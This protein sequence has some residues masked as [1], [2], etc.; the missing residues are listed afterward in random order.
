MFTDEAREISGPLE[1]GGAKKLSAEQSELLEEL[2]THESRWRRLRPKATK[3]KVSS[4]VARR[5]SAEILD[6]VGPLCIIRRCGWHPS[7]LR[8]AVRAAA[9]H[10]CPSQVTKGP[11]VERVDETHATLLWESA[12]SRLRRGRG[13]QATSS[14][15]SVETHV[16]GEFGKGQPKPDEPGTYYRNEVALDGLDAD[17]CYAYRVR[18]SGTVAQPAGDL[19]EILHR[20][21]RGQRLHLP[22]TADT[23]PILG[24]TVPTLNQVLPEMPDFTVHAGD[25][26]YYSA[27]AETWAYWFGAMAPLLRAAR[28][29]PRSA[30]TSR[31]RRPNSTITTVGCSPMPRVEKTT[32][33]FHF[34]TGGVHFFALD[35]ENSSLAA[36][37]DQVNWLQNGFAAAKATAGYVSRSSIFIGRS[38]PSATPSAGGRPRGP[39]ADL[40]RRRR[41]AGD[42][43]PHARLRALRIPDGITYVT[44]A[45]GGGVINDVNGNVAQLSRRRDV[46]G[47]LFGP[48]SHVPLLCH[49]GKVVVEGGER[50]RRHHRLVR[51]ERAV[52]ILLKSV[53]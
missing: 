34:S 2:A 24:H 15:A 31:S 44:C 47:R 28:S 39:G 30:T 17:S 52:K 45:G 37:S 9:T 48:L 12:N 25:I 16:V 41:E 38:T 49:R 42:S 29:T 19:S 32:P 1:R 40:R 51:Q 53:P 18:A 22:R 23:D 11:W 3:R 46:A 6:R 27:I 4:S 26:Q 5:R 8:A 13:R 35:T 50:R 20:A 43:G 36:G 7:F 21:I 10:P 33:W 14:G